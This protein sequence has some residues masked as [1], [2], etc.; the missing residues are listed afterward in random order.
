MTMLPPNVIMTN[1]KYLLTINVRNS[2][3]G[4]IYEPS[5]EEEGN[6]LTPR[7]RPT[8][9]YLPL[10]TMANKTIGGCIRTPRPDAL[11]AGIRLN[12]EPILVEVAHPS[13]WQ[14]RGAP[15]T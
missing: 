5:H 13:I 8:D 14:L 12:Q 7:K 11:F 4:T 1:I 3:P 15:G 2:T 6:A 9:S 10:L